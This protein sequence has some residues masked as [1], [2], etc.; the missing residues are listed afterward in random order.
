MS[1]EPTGLAGSTT[2]PGLPAVSPALLFMFGAARREQG[3][4][5]TSESAALPAAAL[6]T[7]TPTVGRPGLFTG[8]VT[9]RLNAT[10]PDGDPLTYTAPAPSDKGTVTVTSR[11]SFTFT[12]TAAARHAAAATNATAADK[13]QTFTVQISDGTGNVVGVPVTVN[14]RPAN[15]TPT[16]VRSTV[17]GVDAVSGEVT[18]RITARDSDG[19]AFG[20]T[21]TTPGD[22]VVEVRPDGTFTYTPSADARE[23]ARDTWYTDRDGFRVSVDDGHGGTRTV[24]VSVKIAPANTAPRAG[25][26][27]FQAPNTATGAIKGSVNAVDPEGDSVGYSGTA[28]TPLGRVV[29]EDSGNF[30]YTPTA[31]AR[32]A[33]AAPGGTKTDTFEVEAADR[34]GA[35]TTI[36]VSVTISPKN[37]KPT[38]TAAVGEPNAAGIVTGKVTG[39]DADRDTLTYSAPA[40]T[41]KG[42]VTM[43]PAGNFV[44][45]PNDDARHA[46]AALGAANSAKTDTFT[47]TVD[48]G[49]GDSATVAV[50][51]SILPK[52]SP[53]TGGSYTTEPPVSATGTVSG[54]VTASDPDGDAL[55]YQGP[56]TT[57]KGTLVVNSDGTFIYKPTAEAR[58]AAGASGATAAD[59][60]DSFTVTVDDGHVGGTA[61]VLVEVNISTTGVP[62]GAP[63]ITTSA[64]TTV[65]QEQTDSVV[66]GQLTLGDPG[67]ILTGATVTIIGVDASDRLKFWDTNNIYGTY[68]PD[69]GVLTVSGEAT[70]TEYQQALRGTLYVNSSDVPPGPRTIV[71][72]ITDGTSSATASKTVSITPVDDTPS[73]SIASGAVTIND[74]DGGQIR[75]ANVFFDDWDEDRD[76]LS[77]KIPAGSNLFANYDKDEGWLTI[78]GFA[79]PA[80]YQAVLR[81]I[82]YSH[83][84]S[85]AGGDRLV[86]IFL[87]NVNYQQSNTLRVVYSPTS[88]V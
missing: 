26:P 5:S 2:A 21:A 10:D 24:A 86:Q 67:G 59:K 68:D 65:A 66:D 53:P 46:A 19:D 71:F 15:S 17:D 32:H 49:H 44:Y 79:S 83:S 6:P 22:G 38:A 88:V 50:T 78:S 81:T 14:I 60:K 3:R 63:T 74:P 69:T 1:S 47:V 84:G 31:V 4:E 8:R 42:T 75:S 13:Q 70:V 56:T 77:V 64:G 80:D 9:G 54:R 82:T 34:Y 41:A 29:V 58:A 45:T 20:F 61:S 72:T 40:A 36:V 35:V 39:T 25:T 7:A 43:D 27:T 48:D 73:L 85:G 18:G 33:A 12:P 30:T 28:D 57:P 87:L 55:T 62:S 23:Q 51:V 16:R 52:N 76:S 11:G 37:A